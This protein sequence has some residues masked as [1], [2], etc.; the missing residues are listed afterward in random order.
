MYAI[1]GTRPDIAFSVR[2]LNKFTNNPGKP[3]WDAIQRLIRDLKGTINLGLL[4]T[5]YP[6]VIEGFSDASWCSKVDECRSTGGF[7]F[8]IEGAAFH[9]ILS[10]KL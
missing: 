4:Y 1:S 10:R 6:V 5:G 9:E 3:H 8:T 7:I 2:M